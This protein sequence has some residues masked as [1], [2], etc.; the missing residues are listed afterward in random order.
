VPSRGSFLPAPPP[1]PREHGAWAML[2]IPLLLGFAAAGRPRAATL[3]LVPGMVLLFLA[4]S[5]GIPAAART[6]QGR[7]SPLGYLRQRWFWTAAYASGAA[8]AFG[9][10]WAAAD[11]PARPAALAAGIFVFVLG[12]AHA[13]LALARKD[14]TLVGETIGMAG[15]AGGA[16][17]VTACAGRPL[18]GRAAGLAL[19]A[20]AYFVS[21]A[22]FVRA[23]GALGTNRRAAFLG[24]IAP[25]AVL[26]A[27]LGALWAVGWIPALALLAFVP[28][29]GRVAWGLARPP[30]NVRALGWREAKVAT[31]F[32]AIAS[33]ALILSA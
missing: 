26:V 10:A 6:L 29:L 7:S 11:P 23:F 14:R 18:D 31:A 16:P 9:T 32:A 27:F 22:A 15:L 3:M 24:C 19:L 25:H 12:S 20:L 1:L 21:A 8:A 2:V 28:V 30:P 33:L 17:L 13:A 5:L 4:R